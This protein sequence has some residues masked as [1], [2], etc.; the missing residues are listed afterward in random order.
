[1]DWKELNAGI[2][3]ILQDYCGELKN[4]ELLTIG[5]KWL[6]ELESGE[7][8]TARARNPHELYRVLEVYN[9]ITVG[10]MMLEASRARKASSSHLDF[11]RTDYPEVDPPEWKKWVTIKLD[12]GDVKVGELALDYY[13]DMEKNYQD[14]CGL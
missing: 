9:I 6:D 11:T 12:G 4:E 10:R 1:M 3:K 7:A 2:C 13:G 5:L 8:A 14:H